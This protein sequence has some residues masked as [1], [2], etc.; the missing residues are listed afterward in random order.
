MRN[1]H[2]QNCLDFR[3][4]QTTA[5][6][7]PHMRPTIALI[8]FVLCALVSAQ[9]TAAAI[10]KFRDRNGVLNYTNVKPKGVNAQVVMVYCPACDPQ[11]KVDWGRVGINSTA[12][13]TEI[14]QAMSKHPVE[15]ALVRAI[16]QA[17]SA[18]N[19]SALSKAGAQGLM[20][21]MPGT[22]NDFGVSDAYNAAQNISG[23]VAYLRFLLDMFDGDVRLVSAAYNSGQ[24]N[25]LKYVGVPPFA[26]TQVY[27]Q[28]VAQ[29][30][31][32]YR[33]EIAARSAPPASALASTVA[34]MPLGKA[35]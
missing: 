2:W 25:V 12:F 33:T 8:L 27:V 10:Y 30:Y 9:A 16:I 14:R 7:L 23:G 34:A 17:E 26:E 20:Q 28:R 32:R 18:Y 11:S 29:L 3:T 1:F 5:P 31:E 13:A 35:P 15:E 19:P 21:L 22:A 6:K 4:L 24:N